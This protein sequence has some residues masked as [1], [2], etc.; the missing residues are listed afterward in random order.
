MDDYCFDK[1]DC[2]QILKIIAQVSLLKGLRER[3]PMPLSNAVDVKELTMVNPVDYFYYDDQNPRYIGS[4]TGYPL[5]YY[6]FDP[7]LR[8]FPDDPISND[9][10]E[11]SN[12][13]LSGLHVDIVFDEEHDWCIMIYDN[14]N[15][16]TAEAIKIYPSG[17]VSIVAIY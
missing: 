10:W 15:E 6:G 13:S 8:L 2:M 16:Q 5:L 11:S 4:L 1:T 12:R 9:Y 14:S 3:I 17:D 7:Q